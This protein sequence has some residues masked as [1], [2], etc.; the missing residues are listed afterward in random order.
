METSKPHRQTKMSQRAS[1]HR[2]RSAG[3]P[4]GFVETMQLELLP[5]KRLSA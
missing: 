1:Q 4:S 2:P 5:S 3:F